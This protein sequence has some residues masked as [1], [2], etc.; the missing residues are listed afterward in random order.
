MRWVTAILTA[1]LTAGPLAL[2]AAE[3]GWVVWEKIEG[4]QVE[5]SSL[6][7]SVSQPTWTIRQAYNSFE[8]CRD[9]KEGIW[10]NDEAHWEGT[11]S[12]VAKVQKIEIRKQPGEKL[13]V[14]FIS[15]KEVKMFFHTYL[16]LPSA[17][18]PRDKN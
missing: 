6:K 10:S 2:A 15:E 14:S 16:C 13:D 18:D 12:R 5:G 7:Q 3:C 11:K 8:G 9:G 4:H 17:I 1:I